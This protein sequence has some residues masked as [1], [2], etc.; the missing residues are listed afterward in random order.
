MT[1]RPNGDWVNFSTE[2]WSEIYRTL[3][4]SQIDPADCDF[5]SDVYP[6][7]KHPPSGAELT[8]SP[9]PVHTND[10]YVQAKLGAKTARA[11]GFSGIIHQISNWGA[12]VQRWIESPNEWDVPRSSREQVPGAFSLDSG[13]VPFAADEQASISAQLKEIAET[14]KKTYELTAQQSAHIDRKFEE[15][16]KASR[17]MG[18]KDW[19]LL[20][21]GAVFSLILADVITPGIA[22]HILMMIEHGI[23]HLFSGPAVSGTLAAGQD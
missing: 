20:F 2:Q 23:G 3:A 18:R 22:G 13:N 12:A 5:D 10:F 8:V 6:R 9:S 14:V 21:G 19:G 11:V 17:R 16:E 7:I 15:A 1:L 4:A